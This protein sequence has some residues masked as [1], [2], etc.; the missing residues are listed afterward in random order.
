MEF[1]SD[2]GIENNFRLAIS[3]AIAPVARFDNGREDQGVN[4]MFMLT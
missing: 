3:V 2:N 4:P 1:L